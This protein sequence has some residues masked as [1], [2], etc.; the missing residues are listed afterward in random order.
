MGYKID[1]FSLKYLEV[2]FAGVCVAAHCRSILADY[3]FKKAIAN[4]SNLGNPNESESRFGS[5]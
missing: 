2:S 1:R 4:D 3:L 5:F